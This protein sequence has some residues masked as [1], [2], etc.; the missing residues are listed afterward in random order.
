M[1]KPVIGVMPQC[2]A[3]GGR[4]VISP[5]YFRAVKEAGGV[6]LLL[7][8][9][10]DPRDTE[11]I[12]ERFD[13]FLYPG[14]PDINPLLFGEE[15]LPEC[16]NIIPERDRLELSLL[17][18]ILR[19]KRPVFG[20]CRGIQSMNVALGGTLYQ[21]IPVQLEGNL[22]VGH[23]QQAGDTVLTHRVAVKRGTL[24]YDIVK[25]DTLEVNS[26][27]HQACRR[28]GRGLVENAQ[29]SD[30]VVEAVS[31]ENYDFFLG[32]QWHPEHLYAVSDDM[33]RIWRA[34]VGA[35]RRKSAVIE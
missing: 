9:E 22:R 25:K 19:S 34:F 2:D 8:L 27:H 20:I 35:C 11:E 26:F 1:S 29:A 7:P 5:D 14:G 10:N 12:L 23:Y 3:E 18:A 15:V 24:L 28:L 33:A 30:A 13:G 17:P 21:D 4:I 16:G 31:L 6:P 32:V